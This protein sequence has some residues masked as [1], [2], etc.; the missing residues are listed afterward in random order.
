MTSE[1][2]S[3]VNDVLGAG[4]ATTKMRA[5]KMVGAAVAVEAAAADERPFSVF[6]V[7]D[8]DA[9]AAFADALSA[10]AAQLRETM[11]DD[12]IVERL[13]Q[14]VASARG[15]LARGIAQH[16]FKLFITHNPAAAGVRV[17]NL[18]ARMA[19]MSAALAADVPAELGGVADPDDENRLNW[20]RED[21]LANEHH[22]HW[23]VVYPT[24]GTADRPLP[25]RHGELFYYMHNQMLARYDAERIAAGLARVQ[26]FDDYDAAVGVGYDPGAMA[27]AGQGFAPRARNQRWRAMPQYG[28]YSPAAHKLLQAKFESAVTSLTLTGGA[29]PLALAGSEGSDAMGDASEPNS[30]GLDLHNRSYGNH[31]GMGHVL[32]ADLGTSAALPAGVMID[33]ATAIR[34][35]FFWQWHK[36]VDDYNFRYQESQPSHDFADAPDIAFGGDDDAGIVLIDEA[37]LADAVPDGVPQDRLLE[38]ALGGQWFGQAAANGSVPFRVDL[39]NGPIDLALPVID[40]LA[41]EMR[42]GTFELFDA[43]MSGGQFSYPYL[44]HRP[45]RT[46]LRLHNREPVAQTVTVRLFLCP[47]DDEAM[48]DDR[49]LWIELDKFA[50]VL[51]PNAQTVVSRRDKSSS[52][53]RRPVFE[54]HHITDVHYLPEAADPEFNPY[55]ECGWPYHLL[56]PRGTEAGMRFALLAI[57]TGDDNLVPQGHCGS[58]SFCGARDQYP[59]VKPMGYPFD[60]PLAKPM[61]EMVAETQSMAMRFIT[62]RTAAA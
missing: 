15:L 34:D 55:C 6:I 53:I 42:R 50:V 22:E 17:P 44:W 62:I 59:D 14:R 26:P 27:I 39:G 20:F 37:A 25:E 1:A 8:M 32:T 19:P 36:H 49:R 12:G 31:H 35:P 30:K 52:V 10:E 41:T 60:R 9:A 54:P 51:Q 4:P 58:V 28:N 43:A 29:T 47:A 3:V 45:F 13:A 46:A 7:E 5:A 2:Q 16:G 56:I 11:P 18:M 23:H 48:I 38:F 61:K 21:P 57:I 24:R 33:P 40:T